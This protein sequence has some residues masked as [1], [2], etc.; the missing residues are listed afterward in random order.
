MKQVPHTS[1]MKTTIIRAK[2]R[3]GIIIGLGLIALSFL[4]LCVGAIYALAPGLASR[5]NCARQFKVG[6]ENWQLDLRSVRQFEA[7][8]HI[9]PELQGGIRVSINEW[10]T[11]KFLISIQ[12]MRDGTATGAIR[13]IEYDT[14]KPPYEQ[15]FHLENWEA[16]TFFSSYDKQIE[17]NWGS[18]HGC[19]DGTGFHFERWKAGRV[20]GGYG[21]AACQRQYAELMSLLAETLVVPL[22]DAPFDWRVW[23]AQK[24]MLILR[25]ESR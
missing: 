1:N 3:T 14:K 13:A 19:I 16:Q 4:V 12:T 25:D 2:R 8:H 18:L 5:T 23:F 17:N 6:G 22:K 11:W 24:R 9:S 10:P 15:D 7:Y 21:N 20:S